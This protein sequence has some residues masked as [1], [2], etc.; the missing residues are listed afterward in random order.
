MPYIDDD[1]ACLSNQHQGNRREEKREGEKK[2]SSRNVDGTSDD[3]NQ[4]HAARQDVRG[5]RAVLEE[6][7]E[8]LCQNWGLGLREFVTRRMERERESL[9]VGFF[10]SFEARGARK[11]KKKRRSS[12]TS[13]FNLFSKG[14]WETS[15]S[16][17]STLKRCIRFFFLFIPLPIFADVKPVSIQ[18][19]QAD[20][21]L[22][23]R[24][25]ERKKREEE[26]RRERG[27]KREIKELSLLGGV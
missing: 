12:L 7:T 20:P 13:L 9:Q 22:R 18:A 5:G 26:W 2:V 6:K 17:S 16:S 8:Q 15:N 23:E 25:R 27:E 21:E 3:S 19:P 10:F 1:R 11:K 4:T 14:G 24:G